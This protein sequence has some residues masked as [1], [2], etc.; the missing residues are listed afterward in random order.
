MER[1]DKYFFE[2]L[3]GSVEEIFRIFDTSEKH[4]FRGQ[5]DYSW[6][7][8]TTFEREVGKIN[9]NCWSDLEQKIILEFKRKAHHYLSDLPQSEIEWLALMQHYGSPT[10]LL[11][12]TR[13]FLVALYFAVENTS[14]DS[15]VWS[16]DTSHFI[17][18]SEPAWKDSL[19]STYS[20]EAEDKIAEIVT[21]RQNTASGII[22]VE[23]YRQNRRFAI[24]KGVFVFPKNIQDS[25][26]ENLKRHL[27]VAK[28]TC[29][30]ENHAI[31]KVQIPHK[32]HLRILYLLNKLNINSETLFPG[33]DGYA[34]SQIAHI[35]MAQLHENQIRILLRETMKNTNSS[36]RSKVN[37]SGIASSSNK[38]RKIDK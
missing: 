6:N 23:P 38:P 22:I 33:L 12:F 19:L 2:I 7:L 30:M 1:S 21:N 20:K 32:Y 35:R 25:F 29:F 8:S 17:E 34:K 37:S 10:R 18:S 5:R 14:C 36:Y 26:E 24:Q 3:L 4:I 13:S 9:H 28:G 16:I 11:D 15:A 31:K 27:S